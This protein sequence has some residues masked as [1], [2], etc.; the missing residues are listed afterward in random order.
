MLDEYLLNLWLSKNANLECKKILGLL[1]V[2]SAPMDEWILHTKNIETLDY[3]TESWVGFPILNWEA[4]SKG[5]RRHQTANYFNCGRIG[6]LIK[7]CR[8][9]IPR[10]NISSGNGKN[11]RTQPSGIC[12]ICVTKADIG[13]M[14]TAQQMTATA[15]G[16]HWETP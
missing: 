4:I 9:G 10:N 14:N 11:K 2:R 5:M 3:D 16:Y 6:H 15:P 12:R 8:Q 1:K 7:D 13:P